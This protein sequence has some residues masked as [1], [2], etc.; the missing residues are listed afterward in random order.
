MLNTGWRALSS[1]LASASLDLS[2]PSLQG[3]GLE[4]QMAFSI[5]DKLLN[6]EGSSLIFSETAAQKKYDFSLWNKT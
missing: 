4:G 5:E 1:G 3:A 2:Q 6:S